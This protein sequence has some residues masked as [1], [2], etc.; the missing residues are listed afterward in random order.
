MLVGG[1]DDRAVVVEGVRALADRHQLVRDARL[2]GILLAVAVGVREDGAVD[3]GPPLREAQGV[4]VGLLAL[5]DGD[6]LRVEDVVLVEVPDREHVVAGGDVRDV[7]LAGCERVGRVLLVERL[8]PDRLVLLGNLLAR[9]QHVRRHVECGQRDPQLLHRSDLVLHRLLVLADVVAVHR[10]TR[11]RERL[12]HVA[13][14]RARGRTR[15]GQAV[16]LAHPARHRHGGLLAAVDQLVVEAVV[17]GVDPGVPVV[18]ALE[19]GRLRPRR[20]V[21]LRV[22][23][24]VAVVRRRD[25][26]GPAAG[27]EVADRDVAGVGVGVAR[28][29]VGQR[30]RAGAAD[31]AACPGSASGSPSPSRCARR[32][33]RPARCRP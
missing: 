6:V 12:D 5:P 33:S 32:R 8:R 4:Q 21:V 30:E 10:V 29:G 23:G 26:R 16:L 18:G 24:P 2:A 1:G 17:A 15:D 14:D 9:G 27:A 31:A 22:V 3:P 11:V 13:V 19:R 7:E 20:V 28:L 25:H